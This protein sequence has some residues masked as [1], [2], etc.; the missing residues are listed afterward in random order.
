MLNERE[1]MSIFFFFFFEGLAGHGQTAVAG[2]RQQRG[3]DG[4]RPRGGRFFNQLP[5]TAH[6]LCRQPLR[7]T[8][9]GHVRFHLH[10][11]RRERVQSHRETRS[12]AAHVPRWRQPSR[13]FSS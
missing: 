13:G 10:V 5:I 12:Q 8:G 4:V 3:A 9:R 7:Q 1:L 6:G 2:E 11:R